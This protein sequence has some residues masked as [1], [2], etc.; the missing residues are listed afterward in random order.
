MV[1]VKCKIMRKQQLVCRQFN[2]IPSRL[3]SS[4][5]QGPLVSSS[6]H[7]TSHNITSRYHLI[8][9]SHNYD[10]KR[11]CPGSGEQDPV[12]ELVVKGE[13]QSEAVS[14]QSTPTAF[15]VLLNA[16][17]VFIGCRDPCFRT[18]VDI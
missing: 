14:R 2:L 6:H 11:K 17:P 16:D 7:I 15:S 4:A 1:G 8:I 18:V 12:E 13:R 9:F 5:H 3:G 10:T